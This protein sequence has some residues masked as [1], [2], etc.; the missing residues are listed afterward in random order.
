MRFEWDNKKSETNQAKHGIS[1]LEATALFRSN[2][3]KLDLP[4][5]CDEA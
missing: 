4:L 2:H 5:V 3:I 1:F